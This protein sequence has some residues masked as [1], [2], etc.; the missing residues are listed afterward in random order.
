MRREVLN[1]RPGQR[2]V[3]NDRLNLGEV[4]FVPGR[5]GEA[6][7]SRETWDLL[8]ADPEL[9]RRYATERARAM[10]KPTSSSITLTPTPTAQKSISLEELEINLSEL[11]RL[12]EAVGDPTLATTTELLT[13]R[14]RARELL[15]VIKGRVAAA[16]DVL[17]V[18]EELLEA[19]VA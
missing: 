1:D 15:G 13:R 16:E 7:M 18:V 11:I 6:E 17:G 9:G 3:T 2:A 5:S 14:A 8:H 12:V 4:R 19:K 10:R